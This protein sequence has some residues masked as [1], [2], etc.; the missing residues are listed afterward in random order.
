MV[1]RII[2]I[3]AF[4]EYSALA[5]KLV[6]RRAGYEN[7]TAR[8]MYDKVNMKMLPTSWNWIWSL[9]VSAM[10]AEVLLRLD[11]PDISM[12][13]IALVLTEAHRVFVDNDCIFAGTA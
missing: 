3:Q 9:K 4:G 5:Q 13:S 11:L 10:K 8:V 6:S 12:E 7:N 2:N 1:S